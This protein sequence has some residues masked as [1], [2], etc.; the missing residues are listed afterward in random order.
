MTGFAVLGTAL[1]CIALFGVGCGLFA[2]S[3]NS[4]EADHFDVV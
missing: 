3:I 4:L 1:V 2:A